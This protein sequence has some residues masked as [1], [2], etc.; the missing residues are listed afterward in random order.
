VGPTTI[1]VTVRV[2]AFRPIY[3]HPY[4]EDAGLRRRTRQ[5]YSLYSR[6]PLEE[7]W[8][9]HK[10]IGA[11]YIVA[12]RHLCFSGRTGG[13]RYRDK[14]DMEDPANVGTKPV[15]ETLF[16]DKPG[17]LEP[18]FRMVFENREFTILETMDMAELASSTDIAGNSSERATSCSSL[19]PSAK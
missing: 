10:D 1:M 4:Y 6:K 11:R 3:N 13:C 5:A 18:Y 8:H 7:I 9:I 14:W 17:G 16:G 15:C 12:E 2:T 19:L